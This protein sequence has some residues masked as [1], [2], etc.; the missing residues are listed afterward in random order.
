MEATYGDEISNLRISKIVG[1]FLWKH[2]CNLGKRIVYNYYL[3]DLS[4]ASI[5]LPVGLALIVFGAAYGGWHWLISYQR[6][7][8]TP[9]GTVMVSALPILMGLQLVL[10]FLAYDIGSVP[11]HSRQRRAWTRK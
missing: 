3:R 1:E 9:A 5:E 2:L 11:R 6:G 7:V 8:V 4:I 10:A